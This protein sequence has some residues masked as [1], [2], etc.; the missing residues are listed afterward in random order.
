MISDATK[1]NLEILDIL[2]EGAISGNLLRLK[3]EL[4]NID[5][6]K[7][8]L[9]TLINKNVDGQNGRRVYRKC[10][11]ISNYVSALVTCSRRG[12]RKMVQWLIDNGA[13]VESCGSCEFDQ[14]LLVDVPALWAAS[15]A[16][17]F[18]IVQ[19]L[20]FQ[21]AN[22]NSRTKTNSTPLRFV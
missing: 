8:Q 20:V 4:E 19:I 11:Y 18:T 12:H 17:H 9:K 2:Q 1:D 14:D 10:I 3:R 13:D 22:V 16:G 7:E 15:A 21:G 6:D 5:Y